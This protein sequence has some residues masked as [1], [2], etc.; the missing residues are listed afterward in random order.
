LIINPTFETQ[1]WMG[2]FD[3][4]VFEFLHLNMQQQH[5]RR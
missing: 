5:E 4:D 2:V 3:C 1:L